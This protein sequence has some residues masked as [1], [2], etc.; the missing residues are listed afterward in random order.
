MAET[1]AACAHSHVSRRTR[2]H[3]DG[4]RT[5]F[6]ACND[7][8]EPFV[9]RCDRAVQVLP[10]AAAKAVDALGGAA[11]RDAAFHRARFDLP[12]LARLKLLV[13][14]KVGIE[15]VMHTEHELGT[16]EAHTTLDIPDILPAAPPVHGEW[17]S[18]DEGP[19]DAGR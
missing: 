5:E 3:G 19:D 7:C 18:P 4:S 10:R 6:W 1:F 8:D 2:V 17:H 13:H 16:V 9:R 11:Y 15:T 12:L 14:G